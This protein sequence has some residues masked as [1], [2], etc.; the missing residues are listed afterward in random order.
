MEQARAILLRRYRF[1]ENS[2]VVVWLTDRF[3]KVKTSVRGATKPGGAFAGRLELFSHSEI[4]FKVSSGDLHILREVMPVTGDEIPSDYD[5]VL[6]AAYFSELC[7]LCT[8]PMHPVP[9][10]HGLLLRARGF[11]GKNRPSRRAVEHFEEEM[12]RILGILDPSTTA[13]H[14]FDGLVRRLPDSRARL[15]ERLEGTH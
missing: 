5:T 12:A 11:L 1:S 4:A 15:L 9:E 8:E 10:L 7:D 14:A 13:R 6:A 3:G 2:L